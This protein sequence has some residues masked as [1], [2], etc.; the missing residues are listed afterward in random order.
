MTIPSRRLCS[1]Q[2]GWWLQT[3]TTV[4]FS[5]TGRMGQSDEEGNLCT[6]IIHLFGGPGNYHFHTPQDA[7][8]AIARAGHTPRSRRLHQGTTQQNYNTCQG[9][10]FNKKSHVNNCQTWTRDLLGAMVNDG[11]G[12]LRKR[13]TTSTLMVHSR[14][15]FRNSRRT[16]S[17]PFTAEFSGAHQVIYPS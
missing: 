7:C 11:L 12:S 10:Q 14:S 4:M 17:K 16:L 6:Q 2:T 3:P 5:F 13:S 15:E 1:R 8:Q 9:I